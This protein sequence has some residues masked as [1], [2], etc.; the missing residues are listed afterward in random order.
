MAD[1]C[2][3]AFAIASQRHAV[4]RATTEAVNARQEQ[5]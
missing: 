3:I 5:A 4:A 1:P 2:E